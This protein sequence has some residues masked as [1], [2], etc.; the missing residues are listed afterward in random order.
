MDNDLLFTPLLN[1]DNS[2]T[3]DI[4]WEQ[5]TEKKPKMKK[6]IRNI[7][8]PGFVIS[9]STQ[10]PYITISK[11]YGVEAVSRIFS[12]LN[13]TGTM[14]TPFELV[15]AILYSK[16]IDLREDIETGRTAWPIN[17]PQMDKSG[18]IALQTAVLID[19]GDPKKSKLPKTLT[20]EIWEKHKD[21]SFATLE[22][23]GEFLTDRLGL[24]LDK[25]SR[26]IPYD[27][28]F[29]PLAAIWVNCQVES[30]SVEAKAR[31]FEKLQKWVVAS[32]LS[33]RYQEGVHTKQI[34]DLQLISNWITLDDDSAEPGW[35]GEITIPRLINVSQTGALG[36]F[37]LALNNRSTSRDP[38][39]DEVVNLG[40]GDGDDHHI[41]PTKFV[42]T[43]LGWGANDTPNV[44]L[45]FMRLARSTNIVFS[46][47]PPSQQ[48]RLVIKNRGSVNSAKEA[49][50]EQLIPVSC[51]EILSK[52]NLT[53]QDFKN[54][55]ALREQYIV[56]IIEKKF[57]FRGLHNVDEHF[58]EM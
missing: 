25:T 29:T 48:I 11:E 39:T 32:I 42:K 36:K 30:L 24:A 26:Y 13:T 18:E 51:F 34:S 49:Y 15:V 57:G 14:L 53:I 10:I 5:Y 31:A 17:Y 56:G 9:S 43:L 8:R 46:N 1:P 47:L 52:E 35:M 44:V 41:F 33:Q 45:N 20:Q 6:L 55:V 7:V 27:S 21:S 54:F 50:D 23:V 58:S 38:L 3:F 4:L 12:T 19:G 37:V 16:G 40:F 2:K 28:I 22:K